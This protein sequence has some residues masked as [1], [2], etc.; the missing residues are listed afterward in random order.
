MYCFVI[1]YKIFNT[2]NIPLS[3]DWDWQVRIEIFNTY[4]KKTPK[5]LDEIKNKIIKSEHWKKLSAIELNEK[6]SKSCNKHIK[7]IKLIKKTKIP[8]NILANPIIL[9]SW[10][11]YQDK[12][13]IISWKL[14]S[15]NIK[16]WKVII[17]KYFEA[18]I[19]MWNYWLYDTSFNFTI[20]N[21]IDKNWDIVFIDLWEFSENLNNL[22]K[23]IQDKWWQYCWSVNKD[24]NPELKDYF[25]CKANE[26]LNL[27]GVEKSWKLI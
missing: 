4:V 19:K 13:E 18:L 6:A 8:L 26:H 15:S 14:Q 5:T 1:Y 23:Y 11:I 16:E 21:W 3:I 17:D 9:D 7:S 22:K 2:N 27:S 25:S 20:N 12:V 10:T 24:L